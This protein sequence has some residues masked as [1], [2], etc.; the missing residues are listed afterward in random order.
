MKAAF[1]FILLASLYSTAQTVPSRLEEAISFGAYQPVGVAISKANRLFVS[2]PRWTDTYQYGLV[3]VTKNGQRKPFPDAAWNQWDTTAPQQHFVSVQALFID[4]DDAL[5]VLD[6]ANPNFGKSIPAGVKLL[7]IDL[8]TNRITNTYRFNDL[9]L[10]QAGLNDVQVDPR[11]QVAY[12]S[13]PGRACLVV[14]DLKT[15]KSRSV[16]T[17]H[18]STT[19]DPSVIL[20]IDGKEVRDNSGKPF[21]SHVNGIALTPDFRYLYYR[22]ITKKRLYRLETNRLSDASLTDQQLG[23]YVEDIGEAGISHGMIADQAGNVYMGDSPAK[24]IRR[25]T[26]AG[27]L[28]TVVTDERLLWP[29]SYAITADGYLYVTAAQYERLPKF[30][31]GVSQVKEP[32]WLYRVKLPRN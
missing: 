29:D 4:Q 28:E 11:R 22:P 18:P 10:N 9:P 12:L 5:W 7:R 13:D 6:P 16:L 30:N 20:T 32:Y 19:A 25:M 23:A 27:K 14:L 24:T 2:F 15:G 17:K 3:E 26:P 21:S 8:A 31:G 1:L